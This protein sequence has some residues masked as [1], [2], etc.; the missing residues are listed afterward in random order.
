[1]QA[2]YFQKYGGGKR[3]RS[4]NIHTV[5]WQDTVEISIPQILADDK[6]MND[7]IYCLKIQGIITNT[8]ITT[9]NTWSQEA[10]FVPLYTTTTW[11]YARRHAAQRA[12]VVRR[13]GS[14]LVD[15]VEQQPPR[16]SSGNARS[17]SVR[18]G[19]NCIHIDCDCSNWMGF[20]KDTD[21]PVSFK[22]RNV[23]R[24]THVKGKVFPYSFR[25]VGPSVQAVSLQVTFK[26]SA[27][28]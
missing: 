4:T 12:C 14:A 17:S 8:I 19:N 20:W 5:R 3:C 26:P 22:F 27:R 7:T 15:Q 16:C 10:M 23:A 18:L 1:M 13:P 11:S 28:R 6:W 9:G 21:S 2:N 24:T 25:S